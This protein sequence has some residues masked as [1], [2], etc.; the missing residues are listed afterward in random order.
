[1]GDAYRYVVN[2]PAMKV[3]YTNAHNRHSISNG[4]FNPPEAATAA[5]QSSANQ[6]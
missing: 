4:L 5:R 1:M 6:Q 2:F 3:L